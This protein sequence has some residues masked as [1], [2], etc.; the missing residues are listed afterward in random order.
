MKSACKVMRHRHLLGTVKEMTPYIHRGVVKANGVVDTS[1]LI[2]DTSRLK[3]LPSDDGYHLITPEAGNFEWWYFD[4]ID[5][6]MDCTLKIIAHLGTDPLR[7]RFFP[8]LAVSVK[9]PTKKQSLIKPYSLEDFNASTDFCDVKLKN[10]FHAFV[11]PGDKSNLYHLSVSINEFSADLTFIGEIE[12]WK[13]LGDGVR[14]EIAGKKGTYSWIVPVP[15][16]RVVGW[17][18]LGNEKY[19]LEKAVG[20]HDHNYWE[21]DGNKKLFIDDAISKWYWGRTVAKDYT[22]IF[23]DTYLRRHAIKSIMIAKGDKIIHSSNNLI[24]VLVDEF[25]DDDDLK[26]SYPAKL[27]IRSLDEDNPFQ[28]I[29]TAKEV[30]DKRD[31]LEG[32]NPAIKWLIK[33]L[34]AKPAYYGILAASTV[35]IAGA[36]IKG[37]AI[38]ELMSF[39]DRY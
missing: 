31:L 28:M 33:L 25:K 30:I 21:A 9:T 2:T 37:A 14:I 17:F 26:T 29:L 12:G 5:L 15:K 1:E 35:N 22:I 4:V 16:A 38:Y 24:E 8:Q 27:T 32:T 36:Q 3:V 7:R 34:L 18:W 39:R 11:E 20:Y 23:M 13:P 10:E 6:E 19:K